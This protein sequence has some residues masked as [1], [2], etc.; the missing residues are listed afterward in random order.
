MYKN[1]IDKLNK[2]Y[3]Y[4][5]IGRLI[6]FIGI[7]TSLFFLKNN[8]MYI[9]LGILVLAFIVLV[10]FHSK[11]AKKLKF[12]QTLLEIQKELDDKK[13]LK[14]KD[15]PLIGETNNLSHDLDLDRLYSLI[16]SC[17]TYKG[18]ELLFKHLKEPVFSDQE[19]KERQDAIDE[20]YN[21]HNFFARKFQAYSRMS[22]QRK[23]T[24][25]FESY[26]FNHKN[27]NA[28]L[29]IVLGCIG[30]I[31]LILVCC[32]VL[33]WWT[34]MI[35]FL[36]N[37]LVNNTNKVEHSQYI[38]ALDS[39]SLTF[40]SYNSLSK[41]ISSEDFDSPYLKKIKEDL[42]NGQEAFKK[43]IFINNLAN[44]IKNPLTNVIFNG[45]FALESNVYTLFLNW[46]KSYKDSLYQSIDAIAK[47]EEIISFT[48]INEIFDCCKPTL[49]E[50][51]VIE[52]DNVRHPLILNC[53]DNGVNFKHSATIIT[54]SNMSGKTTYL[55]SIGINIVLGL[56]GSYVLA[57]KAKISNVQLFTS[58]R[59]NDDV[60]N[61]ISTFYAEI[62]R[63]KEMIE[64]SKEN[65]KMVCLIDEIFKGT[66]SI[67]RI[68][69]AKEGIKK[70]TT[71]HS[72]VIVST[73]DFELCNIENI[74]NYHFEEHYIDNEIYFSYKLQD[75]KCLTSN[76]EFLMKLAGII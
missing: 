1:E 35:V 34:L 22:K 21:K 62:K 67:D 9:V 24:Y 32:L 49:S 51:L 4:Y 74:L 10:I 8:F 11:V 68:K 31:T 13:E 2:T 27:K 57:S 16:N 70:L 43:L 15:V 38:E 14:F 40:E 56:N 44:F 52:F 5:S 59:V 65:K 7:I 50:E 73:H 64:F 45:F 12:Y 28:I 6:L 42:L 39:L 30:L 75:G 29:S 48:T 3:N 66:N 55:R 53:V 23:V 20:M 19:I 25:N 58:M 61:G 47:E 60:N 54:G 71:D 26:D 41:I 37:Y 33:P 46:G 76:A 36:V 69:G 63:I 18:K 72:I 17:Y